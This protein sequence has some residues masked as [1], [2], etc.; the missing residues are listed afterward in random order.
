MT[1]AQ[2]FEPHGETHDRYAPG[3]PCWVSLMVHGLTA[4]QEFY[5]ELF[6]WEFL[7][8]PRQLGAYARALLDGHDVAGI[9][10]L[11]AD[12]HLPVA[13]TPYLASDDVDRDAERVRLCG[14]TVGVG[15]LDAG[16]AGRLAICSD[17]AGAVF[18]L[19][20]ASAHLGTTVAGAHGT[21]A[22]NELLTFDTETVTKFYETLFGY[23]TTPAAD[24]PSAPDAD[25]DIDAVTLRLDT[26]PVAALRGLGPA[27]P[28][29]RGPHWLTYFQVTDTDTALARV[30]S[31]GGHTLTDPADTPL[32]RVAT[33][34][35]PE[36]APFALLQRAS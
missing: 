20:Q 36:G 8:G 10:Q 11:P 21:P 26:H 9:G 15:P 32:G 6:G 28:R 14:G 27:L 22:W 30:T 18:G 35:D 25:A 34:S 4:T 12:R 19:W 16:D 23:D 5:G 2:G 24:A 7:P 1:E 17:P 13:W 3:T 31:L 33:A 29:H